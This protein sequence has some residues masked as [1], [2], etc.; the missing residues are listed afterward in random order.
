MLKLC[1]PG[2]LPDYAGIATV[3]HDRVLFMS[4]RHVTLGFYDAPPL[5]PSIVVHA[6]DPPLPADF[7]LTRGSTVPGV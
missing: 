6:F 5:L 2:K 4:G 7:K 1:K 3:M